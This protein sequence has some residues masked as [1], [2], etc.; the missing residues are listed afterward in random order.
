MKN[1]LAIAIGLAII[2]GT[3]RGEFADANARCRG[4]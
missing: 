4:L 2:A 3:T 1:A